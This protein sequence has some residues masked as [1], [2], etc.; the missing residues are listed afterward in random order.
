QGAGN[1]IS[2]NGLGVQI[3]ASGTSVQG[4]FIGTDK[5]G[6]APLGNAGDGVRVVGGVS[7]TLIGGTAAGAGNLIAANGGAG[8]DVT[9]AKGSPTKTTIQGNTLGTDVNRSGTLPNAT[10]ISITGGSATTV[11]GNAPGARNLVWHSKNDGIDLTDQG[12]GGNNAVVGNDIQQGGGAG[13]SLNASGHDTVAS[14]LIKANAGIGVS[15]TGSGAV[16]VGGTDASAAN[17]I[18]GNAVGVKI[19]SGSGNTVAFN[20]ITNNAA[21]G[22]VVSNS[23]GDKISANAITANLGLGIDLDTTVGTTPSND[24]IAAPVLLSVSGDSASKTAN[25][26]VFGTPN[27]AGYTV[28]LF[29]NPVKTAGVPIQGGVLVGSTT[30]ATDATGRAAFAIPYTPVGGQA[31]ITATVTDAA[32]NTSRFSTRNGAPTTHVPGGQT[33]RQDATL[34]YS[35]ANK[36][37]VSVGDL[38]PAINP[39]VQV[40]LSVDHGTLSL[41][42]L[43][44]LT[45][46][47]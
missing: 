11:G 22:V 3:E 23:R 18:S 8:I 31:A 45:G 35:S 36:N 40:T 26:I 34:L 7:N 24:Q 44:K 25:G 43:A 32:N 12:S 28:E 20:T 1:V 16:T 21:Q 37:A 47:G 13:I 15:L 5:G 39:N 14:N 46:S 9:Q 19:A 27:T 2:G 33:V 6:T 17:T 29:A 4:N 38:S 42:G 41:S 30:V 10:G